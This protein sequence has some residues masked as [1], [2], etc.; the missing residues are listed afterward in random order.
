MP[1]RGALSHYVLDKAVQKVRSILNIRVR[2][3]AQLAERIEYLVEEEDDATSRDLQSQSGRGCHTKRK[4]L[5]FAML[6]SASQ[7]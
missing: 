7:A 6:Y 2:V 5:A 4:C 1:E 3:G